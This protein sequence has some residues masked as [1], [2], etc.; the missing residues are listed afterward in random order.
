MEHQ[1]LNKNERMLFLIACRWFKKYT[2]CSDTE[3]DLFNL[4]VVRKIAKQANIIFSP[5][6]V[7]ELTKEVEKM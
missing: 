1:S 6:I 3:I 2:N 4:R 5:E 7:E